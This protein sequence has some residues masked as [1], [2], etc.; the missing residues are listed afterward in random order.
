MKVALL[1]KRNKP[2]ALEAYQYLL[3]KSFDVDFLSGSLGDPLPQELRENDYDIL[4]SYI[5]PWIIPVD[6]LNK[7]GLLN[8]N[9]HP[10]PPEYPGIGCFNFAIY[11]N[12]KEFGVTAHEM[13]ASVDSGRIYGVKRFKI[14]NDSVLSLSLKTYSCL[15]SLFTEV[16]DYFCAFGEAPH[17]SE[18]WQRKPY[19][20][21]EL[22]E[23]S[24]I[25]L[26][27]TDDEVY[28][29]IKA[30]YYPG[31]PGPYIEIKGYKFEY[32]PTR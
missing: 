14:N 4:I 26:N 22:E 24:R 7:T 13:K 18:L 29:R 20:R 17:V 8:V 3:E 11:N 30:T 28:R 6:I 9:F 16:I 15:Y 5:S 21:K 19:K 10:G 23:L 27:M 31:M 25:D 12:E 1:A 32:N 2:M